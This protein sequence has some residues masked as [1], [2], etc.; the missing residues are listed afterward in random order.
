MQNAIDK[1]IAAENTTSIK[2]KTELMK[3]V[4]LSL[5][6]GNRVFEDQLMENVRRLR[7]TEYLSHKNP[8]NVKQIFR[9]LLASKRL[10]KISQSEDIQQVFYSQTSLSTLYSLL[11]NKLVYQLDDEKSDD[12][13]LIFSRGQ[14]LRVNSFLE[15]SLTSRNVFEEIT[16]LTDEDKTKVYKNLIASADNSIECVVENNKKQIS[17]SL[18]ADKEKAIKL[19]EQ[20]SSYREEKSLSHQKVLK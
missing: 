3:E 5:S 16:L 19:D 20:Y 10:N 8:S 17:N 7:I 4:A 9:D 12:S 6:L 15:D 2:E 13:E 1:L 14:A 18:V 11:N